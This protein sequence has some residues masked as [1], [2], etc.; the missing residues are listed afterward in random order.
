MFGRKDEPIDAAAEIEASAEE[1]KIEGER[2]A[3]TLGV[4]RRRLPAGTRPLI[5][6]LL[7]AA[8][9]LGGFAVWK[10][11]GVRTATA[12]KKNKH[13]EMVSNT[14]P[15]LIRTAA[16]AE[17]DVTA[18]ATAQA[19]QAKEREAALQAAT[20]P[21]VPQAAVNTA[22]PPPK[23]PT[24]AELLEKRRLSSGQKSDG[25][26]ASGI[27]V[28]PLLPMPDADT[29]MGGGELQRSLQPLKLKASAAGVL[30]DR[31]Y[32]LTQG[33]VIDCQLETR[34]ITTQ[35]GMTSCYATRA[36]Y[37]TN[38]EV[39]LVPRG[40]RIV[41]NYQSGIKQG[42]ARI[43]V[44]W[45]RIETP[46]GVIVALDSPGTGPL[47]EAGV[48]GTVDNHFFDRFG[49]AVLISLIGDVGQFVA[50]QGQQKG[51]GNQIQFGGTTQGAEQASVEILKSTLNIPPT[52][53]LNQGE[54]VAIFVARDLDFS[55]VYSL[56]SE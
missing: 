29:A 30:G 11:R 16:A 41:G 8:I 17:P 21:V 47:G 49:T 36:V 52:L 31:N 34:I 12:E 3:S 1:R 18:Q 55:G 32:L 6:A 40:S 27:G 53:Y 54:R 26:S 56:R 39:V 35:P 51:S 42:Q 14:L 5:I 9:G 4:R 13:D 46:E 25:G 24:R 50:A 20:H 33:A 38:G 48:G 37:S 43:F 7:L 10:A 15:P 19:Q 2:G 28:G 45:T 44:L 23:P 22:P